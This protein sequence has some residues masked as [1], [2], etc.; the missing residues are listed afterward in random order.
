MIILVIIP[1]L[2]TAFG[3]SWRPA[4]NPGVK[5]SP[6]P[7]LKSHDQSGINKPSQ[8]SWF[9]LFLYINIKGTSLRHGERKVVAIGRLL[10][11]A[12]AA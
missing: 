4:E 7:E 3:I 11:M 12:A 9:C 8:Y 5:N 6:G 10:G 1:P 2:S